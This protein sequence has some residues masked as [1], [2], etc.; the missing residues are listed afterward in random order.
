MYTKER[1]QEKFLDEN[2][3]EAEQ[4]T[5]E[6]EKRIAELLALKETSLEAV[7]RDRALIEWFVAEV[8]IKLDI[9]GRKAAGILGINR[10]IVQRII[11]ESGENRPC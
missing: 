4:E 5:L 2:Y 9:S 11:N 6:Q 7:K 3:M 8:R 10:N 1:T